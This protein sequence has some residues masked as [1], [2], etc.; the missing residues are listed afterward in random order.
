MN[1]MKRQKILAITL[2][3]SVLLIGS[4]FSG[5]AIKMNPLNTPDSLEVTKEVYDGQDW[6]DEISAN[7]GE[8]VQFR[9]TVTYYNVSQPG[10]H[11][12]EQI[13]VNDTLPPCLEYDIGTADPFEPAIDGDVL[14]WDLG[15]T[16][17]YHEDSYVITF[18]CTVTATGPNVNCANAVAY[19]HCC[20][21]YI[22]GE[23]CATVNVPLP[24]PGI[25]VEKYVWDG[26]CFWVEETSEYAGEE[27]TFKIVV[28][29]TGDATLYDV[30]VND[31]LSESLEYVPDSSTPFEP[32]VDGKDLTWYFNNLEPGQIIEIIFNALVVGEPCDVDTNWAYVEGSTDC[33]T[34]TDQDSA[35]VH[36]NGMCIEKEVW[37]DTSDDWAESTEASVGDTVRFRITI[38]YYG[39]KTLYDI[40]VKDELP[41]CFAYA[42]NA[43]PE[44]P[45][46]SGNTLWWN[47]SSAYNLY[48]GQHLIIEFDA[49]VEGGLC[50]ECVNWVY[51]TANECSGRIFEDQDDAV[52]YVDCEFTA[53]AGGPYEGDIDEEIEI[54]GSAADGK[55]PYTFE[56]DLD[57]DGQFDDATGAV[58][59]HSWSEAGSYIIR[60]KVTDDDD[61]TAE[62]YAAVNIAQGE[63]RAPL[64]PSTPE[65]PTS[66]Q[67][68]KKYKYTTSTTDPDGDQVMYFFDFGDGT[69]GWLGPYDSGDT[70]EVEHTFGYGSHAIRV[71]AQDSHFEESPWSDP[72]SISMPK[73]KILQ[74][75]FIA[76]LFSQLFERFP[77]LQKILGF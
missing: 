77:V 49:I 13:V 63:N 70:C 7:I 46:V 36:I 29:N 54:T 55:T 65:G 47:L 56:W 53:D 43:V 4:M 52:V 16:I 21:R 8:T 50:D 61:K 48:D 10:C 69:S 59:T 68:G 17:L 12:A 25:D 24:R 2:V 66:G 64:K 75:P 23:D 44:E 60:L 71:K 6:V 27:V 67:A 3:I 22:R 45:E 58:I 34:V 72:L 57:D 33:E 14:T 51:V 38:Y 37:D 1:N 74:N 32:D 30:Y 39:P 5:T 19:E 26:T 20:G 11:W 18:N 73:S 9:I 76:K 28:E 42:D 41:E 15:S 62:D 35:K 31:T 40:K